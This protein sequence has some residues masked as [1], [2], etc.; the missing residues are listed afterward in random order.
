MFA[1]LGVLE[2]RLSALRHV[3][4]TK[5]PMDEASV[6][7]P[8]AIRLLSLG[9]NEW[10]ADLLWVGALVYFGESLVSRSQQRYLQRYA[11]A[12]EETDPY[13][14]QAYFWAATVS[15]YSTRIVRRDSV[16]NAIAHLRRGLEYFPNDGEIY[17]QL[18]FNYFYELP[19]LLDSDSEREEARRRGAEYLRRAA[20]LGTGPAWLALTA[21]GALERSGLVDR[22]LEHLRESYIRT[23]DPAVRARIAARIEEIA[24]ERGESDPFLEAARRFEAERRAFFPYLRPI[25]YLFVGPPVPGVA[26][27]TLPP[28]DDD[29]TATMA[30]SATDA[31]TTNE[32]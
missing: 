17:Y 3:S 30:Q 18:G 23:E 5:R 9:H 2:T 24:R 27:T 11:E 31:G 13:F 7:S 26:G 1:A 10:A 32:P 14:R 15:I 6:P 28:P 12:I 22:A 25:H 29:T 4:L 20:A 19:R 21:A 8:R 16:E